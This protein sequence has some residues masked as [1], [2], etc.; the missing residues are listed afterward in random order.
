VNTEIKQ[1]WVKALRSGEY[2]QGQHRLRTLDF[3][4]KVD[5]PRHVVVGYCC[6]GVLCDILSKEGQ[7]RWD[8]EFFKFE[9]HKSNST[10]PASVAQYL[11]MPENPMVDYD[12]EDHHAMRDSVAE[13]NDGYYSFEFIANLIEQQL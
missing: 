5:G 8:G 3:D 11:E 10:L 12:G 7:G 2:K 9:E 13:L 4:N 1:K 6:L